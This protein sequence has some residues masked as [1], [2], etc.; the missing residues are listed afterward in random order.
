[1]AQ[2]KGLF[3][4]IGGYVK[5]MTYGMGGKELSMLSQSGQAGYNAGQLGRAA[6]QGIGSTGRGAVYGAAAGGAWGAVSD[7]TSVLGGMAMGAAG[8]AVGGRYGGAGMKSMSRWS[9]PE[10]GFAPGISAQRMGDKMS[11]FAMGVVGQ[12]RRDFRGA[13]SAMGFPGNTAAR[14]V[15]SNSPVPAAAVVAAAPVAGA[16]SMSK[17]STKLSSNSAYGSAMKNTY[18]PAG[19]KG[20]ASRRLADNYIA[21]NPELSQSQKA[22]MQRGLDRSRVDRDQQRYEK[23][24][25]RSA[26]QG[27]WF[28]QPEWR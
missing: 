5:G 6:W 17:A 16:S 10:Y 15:T 24:M 12:A 18:N 2:G 25:R 28:N 27:P 21:Q 22:R 11:N 26:P 19:R 13:K 23:T 9:R 20:P 1:M 7:D 8:G 3:S 14:S 4:T